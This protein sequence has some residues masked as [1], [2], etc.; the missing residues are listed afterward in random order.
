M[1]RVETLQTAR[2]RVS[3]PS[4]R[5]PHSCV[6]L[7][8]A[9]QKPKSLHRNLQ[10]RKQDARSITNCLTCP[11]LRNIFA[12]LGKIGSCLAKEV[13]FGSPRVASNDTFCEQCLK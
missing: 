12:K 11:S 10:L 8:W 6:T 2:G 4:S 1:L 9:R 3:V 13:S 5:A 7:I